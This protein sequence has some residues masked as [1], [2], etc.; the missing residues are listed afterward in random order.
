MATTPQLVKG[1]PWWL[2]QMMAATG[3]IQ[4]NS[5]QQA[6]AL[7][8]AQQ[9]ASA[10]TPPKPLP[11]PPPIGP[12]PTVQKQV[13]NPTVPVYSSITFLSAADT[14]RFLQQDKDGYVS[15][16]TRLDFVARGMAPDL[17]LNAIGDAARAYSQQ[18]QSL[19]TQAIQ[20]ADAFFYTCIKTPIPGTTVA[21]IPWKMALTEGRAYEYGLPHT[22]S[23]I[24]FLSSETLA[25]PLEELA[26][27]LVHEKVHIYQ[28]Q[29]SEAIQPWLASNGYEPFDS[30]NK[31]QEN[32]DIRSNPD[33]GDTYYMQ[34]SQP[35]PFSLVTTDDLADE[36]KRRERKD[37]LMGNCK[38]M[39]AI[40]ERKEQYNGQEVD[41]DPDNITDVRKGTDGENEHP[42]EKMAYDIAARYPGTKSVID[43]YG[44]KNLVSTCF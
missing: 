2:T 19:V 16:M 28:R 12:T 21:R 44:Y 20:K 30:I 27:T 31:R 39:A 22:R 23:D 41:A 25:Q 18:E 14:A 34:C 4:E 37:W 13:Q 36:Q 35:A 9:K 29:N 38:P 40:Y 43:I 5:Q 24:V 6:Q 32:S 1:I 17:Y 3:V 10:A 11:S 15:R 42:F 7:A 8:L 26:K 33:I